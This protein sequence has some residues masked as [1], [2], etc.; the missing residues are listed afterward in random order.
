M[1]AVV[2]FVRPS[3]RQQILDS[4]MEPRGDLLRSLALSKLERFTNADGQ[5]A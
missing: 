3:A 4:V 1:R 5:L 2:A